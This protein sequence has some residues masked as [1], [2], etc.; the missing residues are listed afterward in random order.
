M[1]NLS[2]KLIILFTSIS[3]L[4]ACGGIKSNESDEATFHTISGTVKG[5]E[6]QKVRLMVFEGGKEKFIDS[7]NIQDG[8]FEVKTKTKELREYILFIGEDVPVLLFLD[9]SD[10]DVKVEG[11]LPG[12][13]ENYSVS[14]SQ[15]SSDLRDYMLFLL[16]FYDTEMDLIGQ[17]NA[18]TPGDTAR[19]NPVMAR[20]D[21]MSTIQRDYAI[22][23]ISKDSA[24]PVSWLLLRELIPTS[25]LTNFDS[26]DIKYFHQVANG[27]RAK[28][29]YS[30][31]PAYIDT[32][33]Q[34]IT[35]QYNQTS[36]SPT[37]GMSGAAPEIVLNDYNGKPIA[38]SS[39]RGKVVLLDFWASWCM[40]CRGENPNV[41]RMYEKYKDKGFTV[42]SVSLDESKDAWMKAIDADNLS[43][44]NHVSDLKG[45]TSDV[46]ATYG[47]T[48][49]P[50]TYLLDR[51]GNII[52]NNLRGAQLEQK[53]Q[54][55][56]D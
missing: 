25:G 5:G 9:E 18:M 29:P 17:I 19:I 40:P 26:T 56:F 21:S 1:K 49:I 50:T 14:G 47:V 35:A 52:A 51:D 55:L 10:Q 53:L 2:K 30:E 24:S 48:A 44:P 16:Q 38:L 4:S 31:Y 12:I 13:G 46:V 32:D 23:Y 22:D 36:V 27:M 42:Y 7:C 33:I 6:G 37:D 11:S 15:Y 41:V 20:L 43:W 28:Y 54:E 8:T 34:T 39:L 45:W 3:M